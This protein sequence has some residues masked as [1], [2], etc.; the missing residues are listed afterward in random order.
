[1]LP[2]L[3]Q[4]NVA[5]AEVTVRAYSTCLLLAAI[6]AGWLFV[7][8]AGG[9]G[10][11]RRRA[12]LVLLAAVAAGVVGARAL[13]VALNPAVYARDPGLI[14]SPAAKGFALYGGLA[15]ASAVVLVGSGWLRVERARLAD[16][17][18]PAVATGIAIIR[19]GC[20][21]NGCCGGNPATLPWALR[22]PP[23]GSSWSGQLLEGSTGAIFGRVEPVHPTQLYELAAVLALAWLSGAVAARWRLAPGGRA[24]L[25][26][27]LFLAFRVVNQQLRAPTPG[28]LGP[29]A[30]TAVYVLGALLALGLAVAN[31]RPS[32]RAVGEA[33]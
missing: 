18:V 33:A 5:G 6:A 24:I 16:V 4:L 15:G 22:F 13:D 12:L 20:F 10:A 31:A 29:A 25:F 8:A 3:A 28:V 19:V 7:R 30:L 27:A 9:V 11:S 1:M 17:S 14:V 26:A 2:V 21:L 32:R 23:G